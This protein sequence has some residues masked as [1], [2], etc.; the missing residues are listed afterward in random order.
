MDFIVHS[1]FVIQYWTAAAKVQLLISG[2]IKKLKATLR[3]QKACIWSLQGSLILAGFVVGT[4]YDYFLVYKSVKNSALYIWTTILCLSPP[5]VVCLILLDALRR[6]HGVRNGYFSNLTQTLNMRQVGWQLVMNLLFAG[7][8]TMAWF[9][10]SQ[11]SWDIVVLTNF[12]SFAM[13][14]YTLWEIATV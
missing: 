9:L 2:Q 6:L 11:W 7:A 1:F 10:E 14:T 4:L 5:L 8:N 3:Y 13:L 12:A